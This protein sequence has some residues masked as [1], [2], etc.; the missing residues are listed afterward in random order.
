VGKLAVAVC[1]G[2][3]K[4]RLSHKFKPQHVVSLYCASHVTISTICVLSKA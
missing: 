4:N 2:C 1:L 3:V